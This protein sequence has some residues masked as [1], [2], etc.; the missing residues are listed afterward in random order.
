MI[1]INQSRY[2]RLEI[3]NWW[4][5]EILSKSK[6]LVIGCGALGNEIIKNLAMLGVGNIFVV[7]LD[8][9]EE[10]NLTRSVLFRK[11]DLGMPKAQVAAIRANEIND[12]INVKYFNGNVFEIGLNVFRN[13]DVVICGLDNREARLFVDRSCWKVNVPWIDGAIEVLSGVARMFIPPDGVDYQ[14]TMSEVDFTLLNKRRSCML[15]GLDDIQQGKIPTTPTIASIIAGIQV[16]EAVKF[17]HKRQD[18]ILLDGRGFHFN[19]ATNESYIIEYQIDEDS[20]SRYSI[21]K[22]VDIKI[23]SGE[24]SI[25]EAFE[26]AYR[27]LKTDEMILSFNN[28]VL[29]ELEDTT[30]GIK[31]AFYK[32][33]NL[34][35]PT[36]FKKDNVMLKPIMTSSIKNN[37]P[38][39]EKLKS[40]TLA[41]LDIPFNDIIVISSSN[42]E[43]GI[44]TVFTDI[45]K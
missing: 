10:S 35:T 28:E 17:L 11:G 24:L 3:I 13:M 36:D 22:I 43:V 2:S 44:A 14:S 21:N 1:E 6:V 41:E 19:G 5:Q 18:L 20:D 29:Y 33:F 34:A 37:S 9:V 38:L 12:E 27:Q 26:I 25:K 39:F 30:S 15:L 45:F 40:K 8:L 7:D 42:K 23:N 32:N 16:Q 31:R 4:D